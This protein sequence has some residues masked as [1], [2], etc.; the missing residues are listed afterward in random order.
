M[1]KSAEAY[2]F[3][4]GIDRPG[5]VQVYLRLAGPRER[6]FARK[7]GGEVPCLLIFLDIDGSRMRVKRGVVAGKET[8]HEGCI[9][10]CVRG[11]ARE[12]QLE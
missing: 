5:P 1:Y 3:E 8:K 6:E 9:G 4:R 12:G 7:Q 11:N 2:D 10:G